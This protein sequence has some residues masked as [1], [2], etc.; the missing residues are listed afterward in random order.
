M[1]AGKGVEGVGVGWIVHGGGFWG[2]GGWLMGLHDR[3]F[4]GRGVKGGRRGE[5]LRVSGR[6]ML[7]I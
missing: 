2:V 4:W 6:Y 5:G 1:V 7:G 3:R